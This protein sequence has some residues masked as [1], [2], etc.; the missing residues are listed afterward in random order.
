MEALVHSA[1][2]PVPPYDVPI[3]RSRQPTLQ[4]LGPKASLCYSPAPDPNQHFSRSMAKCDAV[5]GFES[6]APASKAWHR[7]WLGNLG[8]IGLQSHNPFERAVPKMRAAQRVRGMEYMEVWKQGPLV[9]L[10]LYQ[11][12]A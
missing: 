10:E 3:F 4:L 2:P 5:C 7:G 9:S 11:G 6:A 8:L 1:D 12:N